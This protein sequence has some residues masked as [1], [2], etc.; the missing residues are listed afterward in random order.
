MSSTKSRLRRYNGH[1]EATSSEEPSSE[2]PIIN[3]FPAEASKILW[4]LNTSW[5]T[6][7][8]QLGYPRPQG[9]IPMLLTLTPHKQDSLLKAYFS[10]RGNAVDFANTEWMPYQKTD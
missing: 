8:D 4:K 2:E 1:L 7:T 6:W 10:V 9:N 3:V 5:C